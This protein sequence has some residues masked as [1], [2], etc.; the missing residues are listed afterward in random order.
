LPAKDTALDAR[1]FVVP[2]RV[3]D[4][5]LNPPEVRLDVR[6]G[7][8]RYPEPRES[9]RGVALRKIVVDEVGRVSHLEIVVLAR[10]GALLGG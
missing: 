2:A 5:R 9:R 6:C 8:P 1:R 10:L 7:E 3:T 4:G